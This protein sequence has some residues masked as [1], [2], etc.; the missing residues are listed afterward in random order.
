MS[1]FLSAI[2]NVEVK[3]GLVFAQYSLV[4]ALAVLLIVAV[5]SPGGLFG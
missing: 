1:K 4:V 5:F 3:R 2:A